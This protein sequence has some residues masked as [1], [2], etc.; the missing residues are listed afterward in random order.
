[1]NIRGG[2]IYSKI[3]KGAEFESLVFYNANWSE[4]SA[5]TI[6]FKKESPIVREKSATHDGEWFW[7]R[8]YGVGARGFVRSEIL[9]NPVNQRLERVGAREL[10]SAEISANPVNQRQE[11]V[12][13]VN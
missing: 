3:I 9:A 13:G 8:S 12:G 5:E 10:I 7:S 6:K 1:M 4:D 2:I 11:R